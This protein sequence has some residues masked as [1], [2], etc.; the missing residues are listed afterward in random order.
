MARAVADRAGRVALVDTSGARPVETLAASPDG[1][2]IVVAL[3]GAKTTAV[4]ATTPPTLAPGLT[5]LH[6]RGPVRV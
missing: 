3:H 4:V 2:R 5:L 1:R 6:L